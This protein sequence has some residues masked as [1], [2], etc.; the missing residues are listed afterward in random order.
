MFRRTTHAP[1]E[2]R[3]IAEQLASLLEPGDV[4]ALSGDLGAGKTTFAQG[5]AK[6]LGVE[7]PVHSP[8]FTLI[9]EYDG[10]IP[11]YHMDVYRLGKGADSENLGIEEYLYGDGVSV[12]EW[13]E[14]V[15]SLL[16]EE[17]LRVTIR[18]TGDSER[19]IEMAGK[20]PRYA[21]LLEELNRTCRT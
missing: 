16:P 17:M 21:R 14:Y 6:G 18:R 19:L 13:A 3:L 1:E 7:E 12:I 20:G 15:D 5:L 11:F 8:T 9:R 4:L 2:T 10:R